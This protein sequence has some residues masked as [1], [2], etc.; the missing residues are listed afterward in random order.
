VTW[1]AIDARPAD[2]ARDAVSA[3]LVARTGQAVEERDDGTV[4]SFAEDERSADALLDELRAAFPGTDAGRRPL[5]LVDWTTQ[6]R[7]GIVA[8]R[9][10]RLTVTPSWLPEAT[11]GDALTVVVDPENAFGSGEHGSTRAA[12]VLL[13]RLLRPGD[14][15]LDLGSGSGILAIAAVK[16]G[17]RGAVGIEVDPDAN[18]VARRNAE[19]NGVLERVEFL[20]GDAGALAPLVG[21]V[22][23]VCSNILRTVNTLLLPSIRSAMAPGAAAIFSGMEEQERE[24]FLPELARAGLA[25]AD[26]VR[27]G[28]WWAVAARRE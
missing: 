23:L 14:Q 5:E 20:E 9:F 12:L 13:E 2:A 7:D 22:E 26:E 3:W 19:R 18:V 16:L 10:G 17:A 27:D 6:W 25:P 21:P 28:S 11:A 4:V 1:W 24:L 15:V 8:R